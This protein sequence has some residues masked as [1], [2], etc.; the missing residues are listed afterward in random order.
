MSADDVERW[1]HSKIDLASRLSLGECGGHYRDAVL[2]LSA[3]ISG[4]GASLW[5]RVESDRK[6]FVE[7]WSRYSAGALNAN[8]ISMPFLVEALRRDN[9]A[10]AERVRLLRDDF[11]DAIPE[12]DDRVVTGD[13]VDAEESEIAAEVTIAPGYLRRYSYGAIFYRDFRSGYVH[14]YRTGPH[15]DESVMSDTR[16]DVTYQNWFDPPRRRVNFDFRW[17]ATVAKSTA[18]GAASDLAT[19]LQAAPQRWWLEG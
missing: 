3:V 1:L 10:L 9:P 2:I 7:V 17:L 6:R 18:S 4:I 12:F 14:S 13:M 15:G 16:G 5:P 8:R 19:G 11:I